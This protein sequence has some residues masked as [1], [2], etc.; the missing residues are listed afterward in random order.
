M[1][2]LLKNIYTDLVPG[3]IENGTGVAR[4]PKVN[5][6]ENGGVINRQTAKGRP[7]R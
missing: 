4:K 2:T 1:K 3:T 7:S 6:V 5:A